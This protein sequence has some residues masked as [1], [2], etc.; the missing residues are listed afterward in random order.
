MSVIIVHNVHEDT[1]NKRTRLTFVV[2]KRKI[3]IIRF[4]LLIPDTKSMKDLLVYSCCDSRHIPVNYFEKSYIF[5]NTHLVDVKLW[6]HNN[7]KR[8]S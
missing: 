3:N 2:V 7:I 1:L 5:K 8:L 4:P 6:F